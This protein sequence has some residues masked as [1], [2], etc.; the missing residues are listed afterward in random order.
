[1]SHFSITSAR[2]LMN[3]LQHADPSLINI[4]ELRDTFF[5]ISKGFKLKATMMRVKPPPGFPLS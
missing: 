2:F 3:K 5:R 4:D 1:V